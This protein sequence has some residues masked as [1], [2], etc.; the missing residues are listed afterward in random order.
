[1][2][3]QYLLPLG[4]AIGLVLAVLT[5]SFLTRRTQLGGVWRLLA[6]RPLPFGL[7][8]VLLLALVP[9]ITQQNIA[10]KASAIRER[11]LREAG[12][13]RNLLPN[14]NLTN[15]SDMAGLRITGWQFEGEP[16]T[17][18]GAGTVMTGSVVPAV[19]VSLYRYSSLIHPTKADGQSGGV[20]LRVLWYSSTLDVVSWHD[21]PLAGVPTRSDDEPHLVT[22]V[23]RAPDNARFAQLVFSGLGPGEVAL[24]SLSFSPLGVHIERHPN[25]ARASVAFS[26]DWESAMGG[27]IHSRGG[28]S[29]EDAE[30][31]GLAMREGADW[32]AQLFREHKIRAT[33]YANGYNLIS[34]NRERRQFVGDPTY[35]WANTRNGWDSDYWQEKRW[36]GDDPYGDTDTHPAWYFGDQTQALRDGGHEIA[37]HTFGHLYVRGTE[38]EEFATDTDEWLRIAKEVG[39]PSPVTFAFPWRSSNSLTAEFYEVL[40]ER[41][42]RGVTRVYERDLRDL[43]TLYSV[44]VYPDMRLMPD[45]LLGESE[46]AS[47]DGEDGDIFTRISEGWD[48]IREAVARRGTIS[49]WTHPEELAGGSDRELPGWETSSKGAW[50][51]IVGEAARQRDAGVM[52]IATVAEIMEYQSLVDQVSVR[53]ERPFLGGW[54]LVIENGSGHGI[55]GVTLTLPGEVARATGAEVLFVQTSGNLNEGSPGKITLTD[56]QDAP[57]RQLVIK[58]LKPGT[59]EISIEWAPG[60]EPLE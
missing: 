52:W 17:T 9:L 14:P 20:T 36:Y 42:F 43:Y 7:A 6:A 2:L 40:H 28:Y 32:L 58:S 18:L 31:R 29:P 39:L 54:K 53:M 38:H 16:L 4:V 11:V 56:V 22:D 1:M 23:I 60:Q 25:A 49:F 34:G 24:S 27:L 13:S 26:F 30:R 44:P 46:E 19:G 12:T 35:D 55:E 47:I 57:S 51:T 37:S 3:S 5:L 48:G 10:T 45:F 33:F 41:G 50:R 15:T 21:S 59:T 8:A